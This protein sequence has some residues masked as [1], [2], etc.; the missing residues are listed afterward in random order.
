MAR[1]TEAQL[2]AELEAKLEERKAKAAEKAAA[3]EA[4]SI[5]KAEAKSARLEK[6]IDSLTKRIDELTEKRAMLSLELEGI[7]ATVV[8][9]ILDSPDASFT[10]LT[11]EEV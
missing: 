11:L 5:E 10:E 8:D 3:A 2:I 1:K 7:E 6:Q 4:K 9:T